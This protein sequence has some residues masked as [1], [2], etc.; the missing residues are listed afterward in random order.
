M[1]KPRGIVMMVSLFSLAA[2]TMLVGAAT[3]LMPT[4]LFAS[5]HA[6]DTNQA[7]FAASSGV[8]YA[9]A[10]LQANT[11]WKGDAVT[12]LVVDRPDLQ[13]LEDTGNVIGVLVA[14][15]GSRS[16]FRMRFNFQN[17][18]ATPDE[19]MTDPAPNHLVTMNH[20]SI[21]NV[22]QVGEALTYKSESA[23]NWAVANGAIST[24]VVPRGYAEVI[25]EGIGGAGMAG[26]TVD[27]LNTVIANN[28]E[29]YRQTIQCRI[30]LGPLTRI[31]SAAAAAGNLNV[32][33]PTGM[34]GGSVNI[35]S[36]S[37]AP[38]PKIRSLASINV[39]ADTLVLD[40]GSKAIVDNGIGSISGVPGAYRADETIA[41]QSERF[42]RLG[43]DEIPKATVANTQVK[44]GTYLWQSNGTTN[45]L[46][47]FAE[48]YNGS[49]PAGPGV[50][51]D[52]TNPLVVAGS[53]ADVV[54]DP[55]NLQTTIN[56]KVF[57]QPQGAVTDFAVIVDP[58]LTTT[59]GKR[60]NIIMNSGDL[61]LADAVLTAPGN[62]YVDGSTEGYG[63]VTSE[64]NVTFQGASVIE[65]D[66]EGAIALYAKGNVTINAIP[67][68]V[69]DNILL[70]N[71]LDPGMGMSMA[72]PATDGL[73]PGGLNPMGMSMST[74]MGMAKDEPPPFELR[75]TDTSFAGLIYT[76]NNFVVNTTDGNFFMR[77]IL[78]AFGG[79]PAN[80]QPGANP[81]AGLIKVNARNARIIYDPSYLQQL[82]ESGVPR[83][84]E[85]G[86]WNLL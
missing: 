45:E 64:K 49:I 44:A 27:N 42:L 56:D 13:I 9:Q 83:R 77:G 2:V 33:V 4:E 60:A 43:W 38:P 41:Q 79:D 59:T 62:I 47:Y 17:G 66:P 29:I 53:S 28:R 14:S 68:A 54:L 76:Q 25:V 63:A 3:M 15:D 5:R 31:D 51:V 65:A 19:G 6:G 84:L 72:V 69:A 24:A 58:A 75:S 21:N 1:K 18:T 71:G 35:T 12:G 80:Q 20:L 70:E 73:F 11:N 78:T 57:V 81:A 50:L 39:T 23:G 40:T 67:Q 48:N 74:S 86:S 36:D 37:S 7:L 34:G 16:A 85:R 82:I 55:I 26:A 52:A 30:G 22:E 46:I 10:R 61:G 32:T 8:D